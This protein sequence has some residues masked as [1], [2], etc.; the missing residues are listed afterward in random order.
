MI[1]KCKMKALSVPLS[2][3]GYDPFIDFLKGVSILFVVLTHCLPYQDYILF[4]FW[5]AQAVPLFLLIQVFHNYK[6][7][8]DKN[9]HPYNFNKLWKRILRP[10]ILL[11]ALQIVLQAFLSGDLLDTIKNAIISGGIGPG[12]Y[13]VSIYIQFFL[14]LPVLQPILRKIPFKYIILLFTSLSI[15]IELILS[16][17]SPPP[18]FT[19]CYLLGIFT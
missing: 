7:Q 13:Y 5:G 10:F 17:T 11:L 12:S 4:S 18:I 1:R 6:K 9:Q 19:D 16:Y 3:E 15:I 14:L 8:L 2:K